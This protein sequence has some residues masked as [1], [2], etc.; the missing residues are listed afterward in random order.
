MLPGL[1][2]LELGRLRMSVGYGTH[3]RGRPLSPVE[4]GV[5]LRKARSNGIS[6]ADCAKAIQLRGTG[7][8]GRF[9][10]ILDL[11]ADLQHLI[12]W[13]SGTNF[14][15]FS[16]A[17]EMVKLED[18]EDQY[19]V[20]DA[21][22]SNGLSSKEVRQVAQ[23]RHRSGRTIEACVREV[24][25]MR[26][27]VEKR[28]VFI[29]SV[30]SENVDALQELTQPGRDMMLAAGMESVGLRSATGRLGAR[31]FTLVGDERFNASMQEIG[32]ENIEARLRSH[33]SEAVKN[34]KSS[35]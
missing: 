11:P 30:A 26:P 9:L 13:G 8:I 31:F 29:G 14:I 21:I 32:K 23:L 18:T 16:S 28:Y 2:A 6:L 19:A 10:R 4:V 20:A 12:D 27:K 33:I 24:L 15:G 17:V 5:L 34:A 7:H 3:K 25:N 1:K 22:L 35:S